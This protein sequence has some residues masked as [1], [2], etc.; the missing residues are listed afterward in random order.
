MKFRQ[1]EV[2]SI[3]FGKLEDNTRTPSHNIAFIYYPDDRMRLNTITPEF[4]TETHGI[5]REGPYYQTDWSRAFFKI[6]FCHEFKRH[7][8]EIYYEEIEA[9]YNKLREMDDFFGSKEIR[10]QLF[11]EK[12]ADKYE[13]QPIMRA[14]VDLEDTENY[15]RPPY[16]KLK[17]ELAYDDDSPCFKVFDKKDGV[18]TEVALNEYKEALQNIRYTTK[19]CMVINFSKLYAMKTSSGNEKKYRITLTAVAIEC[20]NKTVPKFSPCVVL[21]DGDD[22]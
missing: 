18:R 14:V 7:E 6:L 13:Y 5:P 17:L 4:I 3:R 12:S 10:L 21:F 1:I 16:T 11:G 9:C 22:D 15:F 19:H 2:S 8:G 20:S